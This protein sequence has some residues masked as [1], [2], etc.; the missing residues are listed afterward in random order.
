MGE[1]AWNLDVDTDDEVASAVEDSLALPAHSSA[2]LQ[3]TIQK[4]FQGASELGIDIVDIA[5][6]IQQTAT[7]TKQQA[8]SLQQLTRDAEEIALSNQSLASGMSE[9]DASAVRARQ[10]LAQS[11][12]N[13]SASIAEID[14]M[15][16][17]TA[18]IGSEIASFASSIA[19]VDKVATEISSI[20][21]QTNLLALNAAIEAARAGEAGKGFAVVAQEIR[22][23]SLQTSQATAAILETLKVLRSGI[24]QLGKAGKDVT[25]CATTVKQQSISM[26]ASF[27][28][29]EQG[30]LSILD[31][32][33]TMAGTTSLIN[34]QAQ[35]FVSAIERISADVAM[36]N[37]ALQ[38]AAKGADRVV[39]LS[40]RM[41]QLTGSTGARTEISPWVDMVRSTAQQLSERFA[42]G[43]HTGKLHPSELFDHRYQPIP[44]TDPQQFLTGFTRFT[45][46]VVPEITEPVVASDGRIVFCAPVD[47]NGYL[48]THNRKFSQPQ[49]PGDPVWNNANCR[50]RRIFNDRVGLAAGRSTEPFLVQTYRR[51]MGGGVFAMMRDISAPIFVE[52]RHWGGLRLAVKL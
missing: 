6:N 3:E 32:T 9:A 51:D 25:G 13:L 40:E 44:G 24:S 10:L 33:S 35:G 52:G 41:I 50:N 36:S 8:D 12:G 39:G 23:L 17:T 18:G 20:A 31:G 29:M 49:R 16:G 45:D 1:R 38:N 22:A 30:I 11:S 19:D 15:L 42:E 4:L 5:G 7:Q 37:E 43:L 2:F 46:M 47:V 14:Q 26:S 21:R 34:Q 48:P 27:Q 28:E